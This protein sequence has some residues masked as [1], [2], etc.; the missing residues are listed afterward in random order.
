MLLTTRFPAVESELASPPDLPSASA[1][2]GRPVLSELHLH[3]APFCRRDELTD[4]TSADIPT[5]QTTTC[6]VRLDLLS[7]L[8]TSDV[9]VPPAAFQGHP[10]RP[11]MDANCSKPS[12]RWHHK[13]CMRIHTKRKTCVQFKIQRSRYRC[14]TSF[15]WCEAPSQNTCPRSI[16]SDMAI[17]YA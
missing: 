11:L 15:L 7:C 6:T 16:R 10:P 5:E 9:L 17:K 14:R 4:C 3:P 1:P 2:S 13:N 8:N 12:T